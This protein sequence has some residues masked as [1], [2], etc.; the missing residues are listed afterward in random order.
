MQSWN[1]ER[2]DQIGIAIARKRATILKGK[3]A[4]GKDPLADKIKIKKEKQ[5][6]DKNAITLRQ[7]LIK[8]FYPYLDSPK[9]KHKHLH[10][11]KTMNWTPISR[12]NFFL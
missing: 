3:V 11:K 4:E 1:I 8:H 7:Y 12:Q 10:R 9:D 2:C 6:E 5:I